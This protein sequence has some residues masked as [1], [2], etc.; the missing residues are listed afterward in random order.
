MNNRNKL[1]LKILP[2]TFDR[3]KD[4]EKLFGTN[5]ACGG[6]WCMYWM[7]RRKEYDEK[8]KTSK[9]KT[10]MKNFIKKGSVPGLIAYDGNEPV[11]WIAVQPR[12]NY[13]VLANSRILKPL[14]NKP[15]WSVTCFFILKKFRRHGITVE[16]LNAAKKYVRKKGGK[17]IEGYPTDTEKDQP[18]PFVYTGLFSA[19]VKAKFKEEARRSEKRPIMR[20]YMR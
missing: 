1:R 15:V 18:A 5:G 8:R 17:I 3:W 12:E 4:F 16:L 10:A 20:Y 19:F 11:G 2:L 7:M 13:P 9:T 14:D 6:C